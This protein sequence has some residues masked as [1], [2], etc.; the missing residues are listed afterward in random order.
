[1]NLTISQLRVQ[2]CWF[3]MSDKEITVERIRARMGSFQGIRNP[4]KYGARMAQC[5]SSTTVT[6]TLKMNKI[7][8]IPDVERN[9]H[10]F[11]DGVG[12]VGTIVAENIF[13]QL[14]RYVK[15]RSANPSAYQFRMAGCKGGKLRHSSL[16][17]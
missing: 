11:S 16:I 3:F 15:L 10:V 13:R 12:K 14:K 1:M 8:L 2:G 7:I 5:F 17:E 4:A 9:G 6:G